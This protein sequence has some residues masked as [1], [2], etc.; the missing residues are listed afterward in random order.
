MDDGRW[1]DDRRQL[2]DG[3]VTT[4][5]TDIKR[6]KDGF[7]WLTMNEGYQVLDNWQCMM[8]GWE[9]SKMIDKDIRYWTIDNVWWTAENCQKWWTRISGTGRLTMYDKRLGIVKNDGQFDADW[10]LTINCLRSCKTRC[11]SI[12]RTPF[13][14]VKH[15]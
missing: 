10:Q 2:V 4:L 8:N 6:W 11:C 9:F 14:Q 3:Q 15:F 5:K 12:W 7:I 1:N 13:Q